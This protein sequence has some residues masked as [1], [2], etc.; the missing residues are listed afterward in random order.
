MKLGLLSLV[1]TVIDF[2][3]GAGE[4][5]V[6]RPPTR[7]VRVVATL[8]RFLR[9]GSPWRSLT[10][11][12]GLASGATLRRRLR[13]WAAE[14]RL[15]K[16]HAVLVRLLR[17]NPD[18]IFDSCSVRAKRGGDLAGPNPTDRGKRGTKYHVA[19]DGDG[20]PVACVATAANVNDTVLFER[21][22]LV[23]FAVLVDGRQ[24]LFPA[25]G[26]PDEVVGVG[27]PDRTASNPGTSRLA[28]ALG[29]YPRAGSIP[30]RSS[31]SSPTSAS[32]RQP[33][34]QWVAQRRSSARRGRTSARRR[35]RWAAHGPGRPGR[36]VSPRAGAPSA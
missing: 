22:F 9:E 30:L 25:P 24:R 14:G 2:C 13:A 3:A 10:A 20:V 7:T 19:V 21:L 5:R 26:V 31:L 12:A 1:V 18:L 6:G 27:G 29:R 32:R 17:G 15:Q 34:G 28:A 33:L 8:R 35:M 36:G 11:S 23:A 16:A 4:C